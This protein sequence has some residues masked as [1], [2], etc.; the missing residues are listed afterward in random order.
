MSAMAA[1]RDDAR[2]REEPWPLPEGWAWVSLASF[3]ATGQ[4]TV[5]PRRRP[6][7][8]FILYSVPSF[9]TGK[10]EKL[11]G[12]EILSPKR[13]VEPESVLLCK[14][15]PRINRAWVVA[16]DEK[17]IIIASP[18]WI[19]FPRSLVIEPHYLRY[20]L[21]T[22]R[23]R[24]YLSQNVS[25]VGGSL[26]RVNAAT[27]GDVEIPIAPICEQRRVVVRIDELFA[28]I[29][30]G[31]AALERARSGLETW[32]RALL[33]AAVTGELTRDWREANRSNQTGA[34]FLEQILKQDRIQ[35]TRRKASL[36]S[37]IRAFA[38][39]QLPAVPE[40][41]AWARLRDIGDIVGGITVDKKRIPERPT[42]V[43]Y[44][45]VAN[46]QRGFLD[47][48]EVKSITVEQHVA[49]RL[50][51]QANDILLNEGGDRDK[52]GRGWVWRDQLPTCIHQ[53]HVFRVRLHDSGINPFFV[54]H[55]A[56]EMGRR[57]FME[58]GKQTTNLASISLTKIGELPVPI[59]PPEEACVIINRLEQYLSTEEDD[60]RDLQ[61][62]L[63]TELAL[64]QSILK[65][66][67]EGRLVPQDPSDEPATVLLAR[68]RAEAP[69]APRRTRGRKIA[70]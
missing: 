9:E 19:A 46:V 26:M 31:E 8:T 11:L 17:H 22:E 48:T 42:T 49:E 61:D 66:A 33:K 54:S 47:L 3:L 69:S 45:R 7:E 55:Y 50:R 60:R 27:V 18:E 56:N 59:P 62:S 40:T 70:S 21:S 52:I 4:I 14:I 25:G 43:P 39:E 37:S 12:S 10:P 28:E 68:L 2:E 51:L 5:D 44:L 20:F 34:V 6:D 13:R 64:R 1:E 67:F 24:Q 36:D 41:W 53:N 29:A 57:F 58:K 15:N 38:D 23:V 35:Q 65:S 32:R 63:S 16:P 30:E